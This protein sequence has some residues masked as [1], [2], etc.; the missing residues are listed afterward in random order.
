MRWRR[1]R[2]QQC[3]LTLEPLA[4]RRVV[5]LKGAAQAWYLPPGGGARFRPPHRCPLP[6]LLALEVLS[7]TWARYCTSSGRRWR[8][9]PL[10]SRMPSDGQLAPSVRGSSE[11]LMPYVVDRDRR[12]A[13]RVEVFRL[14]PLLRVLGFLFWVVALLEEVSV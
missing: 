13:S 12:I 7:R 11:T 1:L 4:V 8:R 3:G 14:P 5:R 10:P 6:R 2:S 9:L